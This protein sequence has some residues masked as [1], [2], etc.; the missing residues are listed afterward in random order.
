MYGSCEK[1]QSRTRRKKARFSAGHNDG[2]IFINVLSFAKIS[3]GFAIANI[4]I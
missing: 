4:Q 2:K 3:A 1:I